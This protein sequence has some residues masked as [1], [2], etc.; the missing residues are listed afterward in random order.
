MRGLEFHPTER[1]TLAAI[2]L[3]EI[4]VVVGLILWRAPLLGLF[5][6]VF[7]GLPSLGS[8]FLGEAGLIIQIAAMLIAIF[9][10][11]GLAT[12]L[13]AEGMV[14]LLK[15]GGKLLTHHR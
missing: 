6:L 7:S 3:I 12:V 8:T 5:Y 11:T 14:R 10:I 1:A 13:L 15:F 4:L 2:L 9:L